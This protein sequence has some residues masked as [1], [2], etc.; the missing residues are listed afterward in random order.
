YMNGLKAAG[1][2]PS[3]K[4][5]PGHGDT[6]VDSHLDLPV[7]PHSM[8]RLKEVELYPSQ[9]LINAGLPSIMVAHLHV[10][11]IDST[12]LMS[13]TL[14]GLAINELLK[15]QMGFTGLVITDALEM[16]GVTKNFDAGQVAIMAFEAGN[17]MLLLPD[18][19]N[20]AFKTLKDGFKSGKL[21]LK[22][23]DEKVMRILE[24]KY[25]LGLDSLIVPTTQEAAKMAF[26]PYAVGIKHTLIEEA[27]TVVQNK[28]ALIPMVNLRDPK[29][30][31][32]AI[33]SDQPTPF[34]N[35]LDSYVK[36]KHFLVPHSLAEVDMPSLLKEVKK[37]SR[38]IVTI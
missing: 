6:D 9:Q 7:I 20:L 13:T 27:I 26:D 29:I 18:N 34:Q 25:Q 21:D 12:P 33:G 17:D 11:A 36:A 14:S 2:M 19:I 23:L 38:L 3:G 24:A 22:M 35:R 31:T 28:R 8:E 37:Y 16:K 32:L 15:K 30:A 4:H 1:V 10:P 5:F